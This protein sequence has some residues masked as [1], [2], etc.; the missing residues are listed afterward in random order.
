MFIPKSK[1]FPLEIPIS[2]SRMNSKYHSTSESVTKLYSM[3]K[4]LLQGVYLGAK[5]YVHEVYQDNP[6]HGCLR[7][8]NGEKIKQAT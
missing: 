6:F 1:C 4:K 2:S 8:H 3:E 7:H 5:H